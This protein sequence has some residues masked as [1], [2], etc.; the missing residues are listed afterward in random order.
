MLPQKIKD[1]K[2][3]VQL[4]LDKY[5]QFERQ[6][7]TID[8]FNEE[9]VYWMWKYVEKMHR[10]TPLYPKEKIRLYLEANQ[11]QR[12]KLNKEF[13]DEDKEDIEKH[14]YCLEKVESENAQK[15][16]SLLEIQ[17]A[18]NYCGEQVYTKKIETILEEFI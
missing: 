6:E 15:K 12:V 11:Y 10:Q 14:L 5:H 4:L 16:H 18:F 7:L 1:V 8:E 9:W 17:R 3:D 2:A 13:T